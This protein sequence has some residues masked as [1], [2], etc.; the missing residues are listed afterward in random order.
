MLPVLP[1]RPE[2]HPGPRAPRRRP[3][4]PGRQAPREPARCVSSFL[5]PVRRR[6]RQVADPGELF[7]ACRVSPVPGRRPPVPQGRQE[8]ARLCGLWPVHRPDLLFRCVARFHTRRPRT[9][10]ADVPSLP[11]LVAALADRTGI[12]LKENKSY[13]ALA[14]GASCAAL[15]VGGLAT[16]QRSDGG[17]DLGFLN[18]EQTD[19][20]KGWMQG[21]SLSRPRSACTTAP[22]ADSCRPPLPPRP[23]SQSS[24]SSTT[25]SARP[26]SR[27]S[28]TRSA[29]SSPRTC[30]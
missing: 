17:K 25:T 3:L 23:P 26:R 8:G 13:D 7:A 30:S 15:L 21:A 29:C 18:R 19:E 16:M 24:S 10:S 1:G 6:A 22:L 14:F 27:A 9:E 28:T 11:P 2:L 4:G 5:S 20:W 12:W